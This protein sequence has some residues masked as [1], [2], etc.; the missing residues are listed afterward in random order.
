ME[1]VGY[2]CQ[3]CPILAAAGVG[4]WRM[5]SGRAVDVHHV[6]A[7]GMGGSTDH[8]RLAAACRASHDW[9]EAHPDK[10]RELGLRAD[11]G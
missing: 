10:S 1:S 6:L 7:R 3:V 8:S 2:R 4:P 9:V 5:C 11:H